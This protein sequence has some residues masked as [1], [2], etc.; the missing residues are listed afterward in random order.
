[1]L[2]TLTLLK[3]DLSF[4]YEYK[5]C[6][7]DV[8]DIAAGDNFSLVLVKPSNSKKNILLRFGVKERDK[9]L[10]GL[11]EA[12]QTIVRILKNYY[13]AYRKI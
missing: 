8:I 13:L 7:L 10:D 3:I 5:N 9:Y 4:N 11:E 2:K 1:M 6:T 12:I